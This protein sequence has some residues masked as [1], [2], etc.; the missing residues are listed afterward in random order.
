MAPEVVYETYGELRGD[1][2]I[3]LL[4]GLSRSHRALT[5]LPT[6]ED[7]PYSPEAWFTSVMGDEQPISTQNYFVVSAGLLGSPWGSTSALAINPQYGESYGG[8][9][10]QLTV[11]DQA[12]AVAALCRGLGVQR[13][14]G[15]IGVS[16][17]GMVA[18]RMASLFPELVGAVAVLGSSGALPDSQR[19][20]FASVRQTLEGDPGYRGGFYEPHE[21][22][23]AKELVRRIRLEQLRA[24]YGQDDLARRLGDLFTVE[25]ALEAE[26]TEFAERF[27]ARCFASL[28]ECFGKADLYEHLPKVGAKTLLVASASDL[29]APPERV[30]DAY[31]RM[32]QAGVPTLY[33]EIQS[34]AGHRTF[35][36]E[37]ER[38][39][40]LLRDFLG[41]K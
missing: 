24:L 4:H 1:N 20:R 6:S 16:L 32:T 34:D 31:K 11:T 26:A 35:Y 18:L 19:K 25:R 38:L 30:R 28:C 5:G 15:V 7:L 22:Q 3:L 39:G 29:L 36:L 9:F 37:S 33:H 14:V 23:E 17:G 8:L 41:A 13:L 10:P 21:E 27:D 40:G 12:R 2:A